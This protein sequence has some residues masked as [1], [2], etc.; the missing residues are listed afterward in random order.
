LREIL[1]SL[2]FAKLKTNLQKAFT[3]D[4]PSLEVQSKLQSLGHD[5]SGLKFTELHL[6]IERNLGV[7]G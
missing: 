6:E 3:A 7:G 1:E 2:T 5:I 4:K